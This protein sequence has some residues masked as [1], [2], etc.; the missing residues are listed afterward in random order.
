MNDRLIS[1]INSATEETL[2]MQQY[3][4]CTSHDMVIY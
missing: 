4:D 3:N 1:S 2:P